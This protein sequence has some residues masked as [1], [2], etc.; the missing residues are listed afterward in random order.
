MKTTT[1]Q[2]KTG[3]PCACKPGIMRDNCPQC[4]GTGWRIDFAAIRA[5]NLAPAKSQYDIQAEKFL[6]DNGIKF[7][8]VCADSK[9]APWHNG[10]GRG[11][12][13]RHHFRVTLSKGGTKPAADRG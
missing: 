13:P 1:N 11:D 8:A 5:K 4:E 9:T 12:M 7:R 3:Q 2:P 10:V 6:A